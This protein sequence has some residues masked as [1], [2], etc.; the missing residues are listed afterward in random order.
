MAEFENDKSSSKA[1]FIGLILVF[2]IVCITVWFGKTAMNLDGETY[3][4]WFGAFRDS[5][6]SYL[7]ILL[8]YIGGAFLGVPQWMLIAGTVFVFGP[9]LGGLLSWGAT[10]ISGTINFWLGRWA[11]A[12]RVERFGGAQVKTL[13]EIVRRNGFLASLTVRM[14]P[15]GPFVLVNMVA[16]VSG[17]SFLAFLGGM[18]IG[19]VPKIAIISF[20]GKSVLASNQGK[21]Y[22]LSFLIIALIMVVCVYA[23]KRK[24]APIVETDKVKLNK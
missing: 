12:S 14:V 21:L 10:L 20:L 17:M 19:V 5:D 1:Q 24:L 3:L 15:T 22:M 13:I 9:W 4:D 23:L 18:A 2:S 7:I 16:G 8:T 11:G 6:W